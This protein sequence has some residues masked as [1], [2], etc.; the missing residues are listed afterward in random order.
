MDLRLHTKSS[1]CVPD[2]NIHYFYIPKGAG[3]TRV[4]FQYTVQTKLTL[5]STFFLA[6]FVLKCPVKVDVFLN[7]CAEC[8]FKVLALTRYCACV[9]VLRLK[10]K[11]GVTKFYFQILYYVFFTKSIC[12][13][14]A[15]KTENKSLE[16][17]QINFD[18]LTFMLVFSPFF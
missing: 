15:E 5:C 11:G 16:I 1:S 10:K 12:L 9:V 13:R 4:S 14:C 6:D 8:C 7:N 17:S 18:S 3:W 2:R